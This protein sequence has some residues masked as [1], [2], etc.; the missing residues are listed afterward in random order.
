M[1]NASPSKIKAKTATN[2]GV[3]VI[4]GRAA[5]I[6]IFLM[7]SITLRNASAPNKVFMYSRIMFAADSVAISTPIKKGIEKSILK[8]ASTKENSKA[9]IL[10]RIF[11]SDTAAKA[12]NSAEVNANRN[13]NK[14]VVSPNNSEIKSKY[15][16]SLD[17]IYEV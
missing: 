9:P 7:A 5:L 15:N 13:Q 10:K 2:P 1:L 12:D 14:G 17:K 3:S 4:M 11:F 16:Y 8:S 6:S